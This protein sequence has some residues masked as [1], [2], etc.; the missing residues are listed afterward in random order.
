MTHTEQTSPSTRTDPTKPSI[1]LIGQTMIDRGLITERDLRAAL[2]QQRRTGKRLGETLIEMG[3][4]SPTDLTALLAER[5]GFEFI[6]LDAT[7]PDADA[8]TVISEEVARRYRALP[9]TRR[10][11][12]MVIAMAAPNDVFALDDLRV[13]LHMP[14]EPVMA[15]P[16]QLLEAIRRTYNRTQV[17]DS[18][19][20]ATDDF[21]DEDFSQALT[22]EDGPVIRLVNALLQQAVTERASDIH[23]EPVRDHVRVRMRTDG[24]LHQAS[25]LPLQLLRPL[26]S[27]IKVLA[28]IDITRRRLPNDGRFSMTIDNAALDVRVA[29]VPTSFGE[30]VVLRLL[31]QV[32]GP[33]DL[34]SLGMVEADRVRF[35]AAFGAPQGCVVVSGPTGSGKTST[36]YA[37]LLELNT[38]ERSIVSVE[39]PVEYQLPGV[40]QIQVNTAVGLTF[41]SALRSILRADPDVLMIGE[42]RDLETAKIAAE[43]AVTGHLVMST[44]HTT[45]AASVPLRL[46]DMGVEPYVVASALTCLVGQRLVRTLCPECS[47]PDTPDPAVLTRLGC[48]PDA[49]ATATIRRAVGCAR[50][51]KTGYRGRRALYELIPVDEQIARLILSRASAHEIEQRAIVNGVDTLHTVALR[52][53]LAGELTVEEMLRVIVQ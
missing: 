33:I 23:I 30:A 16:H 19:D 7:T 13:L 27:R 38:V 5:M 48:E 28:G 12:H 22:D 3:V 31:D 9:L 49:L 4:V 21:E 39:D 32:R 6:D 2:T 35:E 14:L 51:N 47:E 25:E 1:P 40:K 46:I 44:I 17:I 53:V 15:E 20:D 52:Q 8:V 34:D 18:V 45:R 10:D 41:A 26:I 42:V 43:A 36:L 24:V 37:A 29:T 11:G 50:C